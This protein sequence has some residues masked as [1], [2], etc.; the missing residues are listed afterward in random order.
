MYTDICLYICPYG[1]HLNIS[2]K[3]TIIP[4]SRQIK[5]ISIISLYCHSLVTLFSKIQSVIIWSLSL[6]VYIIIVT[7]A[8]VYIYIYIYIYI[9]YIKT[10][11]SRSHPSVCLSVCLS[12]SPIFLPPLSLSLSGSG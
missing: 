9:L 6:Y 12:A 11:N 2:H 10:H 1:S 4:D 3:M 7:V 5:T 8:G